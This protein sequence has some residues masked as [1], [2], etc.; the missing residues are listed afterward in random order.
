[1]MTHT[2]SPT[3]LAVGNG[4]VRDGARRL[5]EEVASRPGGV[6]GREVHLDFQHVEFVESRDLGALVV[7]NRKVKGAGGKLALVNVRPVVSGVLEVTRLDTILEVH[8]NSS[9]P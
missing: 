2:Q 1:M 9:N 6:A 3:V 8:R 4:R 5:A 7:L